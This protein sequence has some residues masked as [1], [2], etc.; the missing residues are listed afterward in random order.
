MIHH[1]QLY[2][3]ALDGLHVT[4][5]S[6]SHGLH[7]GSFYVAPTGEKYVRREDGKLYAD[8]CRWDEGRGYRR[9]NVD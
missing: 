8:N 4:I 3:G 6:T 1:E 2:G 9:S 5:A 7:P